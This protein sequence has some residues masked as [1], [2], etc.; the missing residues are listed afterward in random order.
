MKKKI[1]AIFLC[2]ALVAIAIVGASLAYFTDTKSATNTFVVGNVKIELIEQQR[3]EN[4]LVPFEQNKKLVPGKSNDGNAVSKIVTV[5]NTGAN[6]AWVWVDMLIPSYLLDAAN[7]TNQSL[8]AL[9]FNEYGA[10]NQAYWQNPTYKLSE[11]NSAVTDGVFKA[12]LT[13]AVEN[14]VN[15]DENT[16]WTDWVSAGTTTVGEGNKAVTYTILRTKM[17]GTLESGKISLPCLRQ[18]YMDWRVQVDGEQY[19]LP[20]GSEIPTNASW[21]IIVNAYAIQA[22]GFNTVDEA[23]AGYTNNG[24]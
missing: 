4:G 5:K 13:P 7:P 12:D 18:V 15:C 19:I 10:F 2:V 17:V 16:V 20:N 1:T 11:T 6:D 3:G 14:M 23:I 22:D 8:N 9:H 24:N 21:E